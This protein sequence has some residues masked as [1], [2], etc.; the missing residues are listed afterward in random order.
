MFFNK[1]LFLEFAS[2]DAIR[3]MPALKLRVLDG[4][5]VFDDQVLY[6]FDGEECVYPVLPEWC[7]HSKQE[8]LF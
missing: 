4:R 3:S 5:E 2:D 6:Q 7:D 8:S 1:R